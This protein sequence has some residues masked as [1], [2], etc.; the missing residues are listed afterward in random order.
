MR[1]ATPFGIV[2]ER[3]GALFL[4]ALRMATTTLRTAGILAGCMVGILATN[5]GRDAPDA[6]TGTA[7]L[8]CIALHYLRKGQ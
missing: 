2:A 7:A 4:F 8:H 6:A 3:G 5:R 1:V